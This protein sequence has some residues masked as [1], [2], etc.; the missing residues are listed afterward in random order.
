MGDQTGSRGWI[1]KEWLANRAA[2]SG[3][4]VG[5]FDFFHV[6][7]GGSGIRQHCEVKFCRAGLVPPAIESQAILAGEAFP[8]DTSISRTHAQAPG[9]VTLTWNRV[10]AE[11]IHPTRHGAP[12]RN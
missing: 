12:H 6:D 2:S 1:V 11:K 8:T 5:E 10:I 3:S 9:N 7:L 4:R